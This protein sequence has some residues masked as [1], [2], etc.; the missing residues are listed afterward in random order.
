MTYIIKKNTEGKST[1]VFFPWQGSKPDN[2]PIENIV[3]VIKSDPLHGEWVQNVTGFKVGFIRHPD[4]E[5]FTF[6]SMHHKAGVSCANCHMP[7]I[8]MGDNK[9][10]DHNVTSPL[11][12]G[13]KACRQCHSKSP[14]LMASQVVAIQD[15]TVSTIN[16]AGYAEAVAAK[17][18]EAVHNAQR[19]GKIIDKTLYDKAKDLYLEALY[20]VIYI[21]AENSVGFHNPSEAGRICVDALAMANKA[22][23]L[24]RQAMTKAGVDV[25]VNINLEMAKY[26]ND[27]GVKKL[28]FRPELEFKDPFGTQDMINPAAS[29]GK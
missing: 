20:R 3:K 15:R 28:K 18:F 6:N 22:E 1:A 9:I 17:M 23:S 21:G 7:Y 11:K 5:F 8:S 24:L 4:Y 2:I 29:L 16:R 19:K 12:A 14:E 13:M 25:P 26:L 27:R 10:S